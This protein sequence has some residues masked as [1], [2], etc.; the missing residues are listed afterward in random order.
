M[1]YSNTFGVLGFVANQPLW[2]LAVP[3]RDALSDPE[4]LGIF[5]VEVISEIFC[6]GSSYRLEL[7]GLTTFY[8]HSDYRL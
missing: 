1:E 4:H 7:F 5:D 6:F 3:N 8:H 2:S